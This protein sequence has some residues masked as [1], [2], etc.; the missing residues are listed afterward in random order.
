MT[1]PT[2]NP[3]YSNFCYE[4]PFMP[5]FTAY[6]DTPVIPTQAFADGYNLPDSEYPDGTP[7]IVSVVNTNTSLPQGPWVKNGQAHA[8]SVSFSLSDVSQGD[9][10]NSVVIGTTTLTSGTITCPTGLFSLCTFLSQD[11]RN[12]Y[13]AT[14]LAAN[15]NSRT[16]TTGY[17]AQLPNP[18]QPTVV[19]TAPISVPNGTTVTVEPVRRDGFAELADTLGWDDGDV[20]AEPHGHRA[21][22]QGRA[23]PDFSGPNSTVAP[24]N[25]KTI[26]RHYGFGAGRHRS[27]SARARTSQSAA[28]R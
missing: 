14:A 26:T 3:A 18:L 23:E 7:A 10:I 25:Q 28:C 19:I 13:L 27:P 11:I 4:T 6:M 9:R 21:R 2:Y 24:Y 17:S 16:G 15:I 1:D 12:L 8:A 20:V 5:G 22:Q